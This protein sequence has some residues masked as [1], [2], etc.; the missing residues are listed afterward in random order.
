MKQNV[1]MYV[2]ICSM[3][4]AFKFQT[5]VCGSMCALRP[6]TALGVIL[7]MLLL[8]DRRTCWAGTHYLG[9]SDWPLSFRNLATHLLSTGITSNG[10]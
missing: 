2:Q 3:V 6:K 4:W 5:W 8:W 10:H 1:Y 9:K 7:H